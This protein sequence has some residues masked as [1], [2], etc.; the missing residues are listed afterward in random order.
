MG[1]EFRLWHL[2]I[3][4]PLISIV[5]LVWNYFKPDAHLSLWAGFFIGIFVSILIAL[6]IV[7]I[8]KISKKK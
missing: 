4:I 8:N 3:L 5:L 6:I 7:G 2:L 1:Y